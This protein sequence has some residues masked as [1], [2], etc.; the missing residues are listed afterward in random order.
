[1][2]EGAPAPRSLGWAHSGGRPRPHRPHRRRGAAR[3]PTRCSGTP[4]SACSRPSRPTSWTSG[5]APAAWPSRSRLSV[6][7]SPWS[8][9][10]RTPWPRWPA[11]PRSP[12]WRTRSWPGRATPTTCRSRPSTSCCAT[13][14]W[15][16]STTRRARWPAWPGPSGRAAG[17]SLL[18]AQRSAAVVAA[19]LS[20]H[21]VR[22]QALL[23]D[24]A[25]RWGEHDSL[26]RRFDRADVV[27]LVTAA[28]L[29]TTDIHG[30]APAGRPGQRAAARVRPGRRGTGCASWTAGWRPHRST[31][32][33]RPRCTCWP[34]APAKEP[35][36]SRRQVERSFDDTGADDG[37]LHRPARR[38][39]R[40]LR[41]GVAAGA[42]RA[43]RAA[44]D[45]RGQRDPWRRPVRDVRSADVRRA[46]RHADEP[47][48]PAVS[49]GDRA[50]AGLRGLPGGFARGDGRLRR[51]HPPRRAALPRR[52]LPRRRGCGPPARPAGRDRGAD[53]HPGR[54]RAGHHLLG[55]G[56]GQ[57]VRRQAGLL[58]GQAGRPDRRA[59]GRRRGLPPP[60]AGRRPLGRG[61]EDRGDAAPA[62]PADRRRHRPHPA[63]HPAPRAGPGRRR[64]PARA[65]LGP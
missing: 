59:A 40:V 19:A 17:L 52:G 9:R 10:A 33:C 47:G 43:A 13:A 39:G 30:P 34:G 31:P 58:D 28:G 8:T 3:C 46:G 21:L 37:R 62:G 14:S 7:G 16:T 45:R 36:V 51:R 26:T 22:A 50:A 4:S 56:G 55:R 25:G 44:G 38:H 5:A 11:G 24:P 63:G 32:G 15:S 49:R 65:R 2:A 20:G 42:S 64:P 1:M 27:D 60:A 18:V 48:A 41:L 61:G 57:Q 53:P 23:D 54:R 6:T 35:A 12:V 29:E